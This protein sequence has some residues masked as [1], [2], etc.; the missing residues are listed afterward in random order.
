MSYKPNLIGISGHIGSGK[1]TVY[2]IINHLSGN[3]R[4]APYH[5]LRT[6]L[7]KPFENKKFAYKLKQI[8]A[9]LLGCTVEDLEDREFKEK[10][11]GPEWWYWKFSGDKGDAQ[12]LVPYVGHVVKYPEEWEL[13]KATPRYLMQITGTEFGRNIIH[14]NIWCNALFSEYKGDTEVWKDIPGYNQ[15]YQVS[16]FGRVRS[17]DRVIIYGEGKGEYHSRKGQVLKS[18]LYGG[19]LTVSLSGKTRTVHSLVAEQFVVKS[20]P[21]L[22][23]NHI[24]CNR[25]NNFYKNLEY[26]SQG[27]NAKH[28]YLTGRANIGVK[29]KD[30]KLN[31]EKVLEIKSLLAAGEVTQ[32]SIA[33]KFSVCATTITDIKKGRK[34]SHIGREVPIIKP[35]LPQM[36]DKWIISDTRFINEV[37]AIKERGGVVVR[38]NRPADVDENP[39]E[40]K[41]ASET[42]LDDYTDWDY[43]I[44]NDGTLEDLVEKVRKM[45][46]HFKITS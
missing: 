34:W 30:A 32:K 43:V 2:E 44:E 17:M 31:E 18:T 40:S 45:L 6:M 14:P 24:D 20:G 11:L 38:V 16:T 35:I 4:N 46:T 15:F 8:V 42:A 25:F 33:D 12:T 41:H 37:A 10:E 39:A 13:V 36:P 28:S 5:E 1:D 9:L 21:N 27:D 23:V 19:Y 29:Q 22:V 26:I 7:D 3:S